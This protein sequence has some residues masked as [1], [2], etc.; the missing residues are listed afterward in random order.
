MVYV[1]KEWIGLNNFKNIYF[2]I[3]QVVGG[4]TFGD[5]ERYGRKQ[6]RKREWGLARR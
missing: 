3:F 5:E 4:V 6:M 1:P 2:I